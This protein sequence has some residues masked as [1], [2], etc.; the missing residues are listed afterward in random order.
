[1]VGP[2]SLFRGIGKTA[3]K[4]FSTPFVFWAFRFSGEIAA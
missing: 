1:V 4:I 3:S 2:A